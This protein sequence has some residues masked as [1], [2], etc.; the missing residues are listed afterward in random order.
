MIKLLHNLPPKNTKLGIALS[1][2]VDSMM[3]LDFLLRGGRMPTVF[4]YNH[5]TAHGHRAETFVRG[6]CEDYGLDLELDT[7][8][9]EKPDGVSSEEFWRDS[10]YSFFE[11]FFDHTIVMA[12]HLDD[13]LE[14]WMF[15]TLHGKPKLIPYR[16]ENVIRPFLLTKKCDIIE[17]V[18]KNEISYIN[19]ESNDSLKYMRNR[20]RHKV[21]PE[22]LKV[23]PGL[24]KHIE[25]M[26]REKHQCN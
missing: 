8:I 12:H 16:R 20:I 13:C 9:T 23:N 6:V 2:G 4:Y 25:K 7:I 5:G 10:R 22:A 1:G 15:S 24:H 18:N 21:L 3:A 19:D 26:L 14:T 17:W 11:K